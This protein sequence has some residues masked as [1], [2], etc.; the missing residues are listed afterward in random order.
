MAGAAKKH[1]ALCK[2]TH[3]R[4]AFRRR[5]DSDQRD[6]VRREDFNDS[7]DKQDMLNFAT[8]IDSLARVAELATQRHQVLANNLA[9]V[10]TQGYQRLDAPFADEVRR[11]LLAEGSLDTVQ[12]QVAPTGEPTT[13]LDG[14]NVDVDRE[15]GSLGQ[16]ALLHQT[17]TE[18]LSSRLGM[19]RRAAR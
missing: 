13:R 16:N 7:T 3:H 1:S 12:P 4:V 5:T 15:I 11:Q 10:N 2:A 8:Q 14:N 19:L 6:S 9:N 18:L 17:V